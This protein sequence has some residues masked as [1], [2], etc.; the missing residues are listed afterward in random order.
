MFGI[1]REEIGV[2]VC[3]MW[4]S[5]IYTVYQIVGYPRTVSNG[6]GMWNA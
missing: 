5:I 3:I 6:E 4:T 1:K 2:K